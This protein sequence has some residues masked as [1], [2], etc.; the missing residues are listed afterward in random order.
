MA[1]RSEYTASC[2]R[3]RESIALNSPRIIFVPGMKPKPP[4]DDHRHELLRALLAGLSWARPEAARRLGA[5]PDRFTLIS[6]THRFYGRYRDIGLD[7]PGVDRILQSPEPTEEDL[8]EI[9]STARRVRRLWHVLG[10]ALPFLGRALAPSDVRV[11]MAEVHR[12]FSDE[13]GIATEIRALVKAALVRAF[14]A[15]ERIALIGH[16]LG[17]VIAYDSLWELSRDA[18]AASPP[19]D[20]FVTLG[21]PLATRFIRGRLRGAG[22]TGSERY[23][24]NIRRWVNFAAV[25]EMTALRPLRPYFAP[26]LELGLVDS[27]E[28][29][30]RLYNHFRSEIGLN[31]HMSYGYLVHREVCECIG[32][33]LESFG[34]EA[35]DRY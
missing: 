30:T 15:G 3:L 26:M 29:H 22:R 19:I 7:V 14:R 23:P 21:S 24:G 16:S 20:L 35:S 25:G 28:D 18:A 17:S 34:E 11:T 12:Y 31:V 5:H 32:T 9:E 27:I 8:R 1:H 33:W 13:R 4:A 2:R 6:W 10:D